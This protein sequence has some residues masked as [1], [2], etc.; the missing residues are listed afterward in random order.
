[1]AA[2]ALGLAMATSLAA[3]GGGAD[4]ASGSGAF[5]IGVIVDQSGPVRTVSAPQ[6]VGLKAAVR[7]VN[8]GGGVDGHK[9]ELVIRDD[10]SDAAKG[11][12]AFR[13]LVDKYHVTTVTGFTSSATIPGVVNFAEQSKVSMLAAGVPGDLLNPVNPVVFTTVASINAQGTAAVDYLKTL[14]DDGKLPAN[15]KVAMF[16]YSSPA[17]ESWKSAVEPYLKEVGFDLVASETAAVGAPSY[18]AAVEAIVAA[19][20][21]AVL[22][23]AAETDLINMMKSAQA[24]GLDPKIPI[25]NYSF[26]SGATALEGVS[27][28]GFTDY[29]ASTPFNSSGD[30]AGS[31]AYVDAIAKAGGNPNQVMVPEGYA[32]VQMI[33]DVLEKCGYPCSSDKFLDI[34]GDFDSDLGGLAF[35]PVKY[36]DKQHFGPTSVAFLGWDDASSS[37][38]PVKSGIPLAG[39]AS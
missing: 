28:L 26:G 11:V 13:E 37:A 24:A 22:L 5:K 36:D 25:V 19:K 12:A 27:K 30:N 7:A 10:G 31:K 21:D 6:L 20:P 9:I 16:H 18:S 15:P 8:D 2:G 38:K 3:C 34:V 32:Q 39:P 4:S 29:V 35:G 33:V 14:V 23:T 17:G 1:M